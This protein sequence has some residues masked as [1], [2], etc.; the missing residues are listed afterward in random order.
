VWFQGIDPAQLVHPDIT[1]QR[2]MT[3]SPKYNSIIK[4]TSVRFTQVYSLVLAFFSEN[5]YNTTRAFYDFGLRPTTIFLLFID[6]LHAGKECTD[7][8][9]SGYLFNC[10]ALKILIFPRN[11]TKTET[12]FAAIS[13]AGYFDYNVVTINNIVWND[14]FANSMQFHKAHFWN[15]NLRH[16]PVAIFSTFSIYLQKYRHNVHICSEMVMNH[17]FRDSFLC[18]FDIMTTIYFAQL[19]NLSIDMFYGNEHFGIKHDMQQIIGASGSFVN[20]HTTSP[21]IRTGYT[22]SGR[23]SNKLIYCSKTVVSSKS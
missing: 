20:A 1:Y 7:P 17:K 5:K 12:L 4:E 2:Y 21:Y 11:F 16:I 9:V 10:A 14:L 3:Y 23:N 19:H 18:T 13:S 22:L 8:K 6:C 15:G